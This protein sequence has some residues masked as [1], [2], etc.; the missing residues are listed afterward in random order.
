MTEQEYCDLRDLQRIESAMSILGDVIP[1]NSSVVKEKDYR[2][3]GQILSNWKDK[4][5][6]LINADDQ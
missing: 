4:L 6:E 1:H 3:I 5:Y 2:M